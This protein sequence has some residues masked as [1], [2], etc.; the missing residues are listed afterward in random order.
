MELTLVNLIYFFGRLA[1]MMLV[2]FFVLVSVFNA[3]WKGMVYLSGIIFSCVV[4][5]LASNTTAQLFM[6]TDPNM[7]SY[8]QVGD[9][10]YSYYPLS[11]VILG[12]TIMYVMLPMIKASG[13]VNN[14][15]LIGVMML[16]VLVD[17]VFLVR[18][19]CATMFY[20]PSPFGEFVPIVI[21]YGIGSL[22]AFLYVLM[23][24]STDQNQLLFFGS[25]ASGPLCKT[26]GKQKM[27]CRVYRNGEL[28]TT[29]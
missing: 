8:C 12:F 3:D 13:G 11:S 10:R 14:V 20:L 4:A 9:T 2:S 24:T 1:P 26:S 21:S 7:S 16:F 25:G 6:T 5:I 15:L 27:K 22:I 19:R 28:I 29:A 18:N 17:V 23:A